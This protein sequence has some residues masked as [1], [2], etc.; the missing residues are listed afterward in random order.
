VD[1]YA[2]GHNLIPFRALFSA[3]LLW[4]S[5]YTDREREMNVAEVARLQP[6]AWQALSGGR[7]PSQ[8]GAPCSPVPLGAAAAT[9]PAVLEGTVGGWTGARTVAF[10]LD[11]LAVVATAAAPT[12]DEIVVGA[13]AAGLAFL[14]YCLTQRAARSSWTFADGLAKDPHNLLGHYVVTYRDGSEE[15]IDVRLGDNVSRPDLV[16]G[17]DQASCPFW[18]QPA[19]EGRDSEGKRVTL[20]SHEWA[21]PK[22]EEPIATV[23][24]RYDGDAA[25]EAL[26]LVALSALG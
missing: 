23:R 6:L 11:G 21:N 26:V 20:W 5:H 16:F 12:G 3:N 18:A 14:H 19:W 22:P 24:L 25:G 17:E 8:A 10:H 13:R 1:E 15:T 7:L 2:Y 9:Y 4:W